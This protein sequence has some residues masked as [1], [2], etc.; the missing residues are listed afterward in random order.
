MTSL[1]QHFETMLPN[2][3]TL[4][5]CDLWDWAPGENHSL[6][7]FRIS[8][9]CP[10]YIYIHLHTNGWYPMWFTEASTHACNRSGRHLVALEGDI[11][12]K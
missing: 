12:P 8:H 9:L 5:G 7:N 6:F 10:T 1:V 3:L 2:I 11:S 4:L